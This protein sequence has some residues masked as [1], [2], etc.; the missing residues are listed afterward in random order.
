MK[1]MFCKGICGALAGLLAFTSCLSGSDNNEA[2]IITCTTELP[3]SYTV[4]GTVVDKATGQPVP[5]IEMKAGIP[6]D[7]KTYFPD[8]ITSRWTSIA[9]ETG[10]FELAGIVDFAYWGATITVMDINNGLFKADTVEV[11]LTKFEQNVVD[12]SVKWTGAITIELEAA[13]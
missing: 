2:E 6:E 7:L 8:S 12:S 1:K 11:D 10:R 9:D 3:S 4:Q 13:E 5:G